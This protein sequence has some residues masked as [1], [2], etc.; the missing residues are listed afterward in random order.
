MT[1]VSELARRID[2]AI[3]AVEDKAQQQMRARLQEFQTRQGQITEYEKAQTRIVEIAK[4][5]LEALA[6]RAGERAK[7]TPAVSQTRRAATFEF[8]S[9]KA[10]MDLTFAVA[11]DQDLKRAV[12]ECDLKVVPVLWKFDSHSEF[13]TPID[14]VDA[15]GLTRWLDDR[16][17]SFVDLFIQV[18]EGEIFDKAEMVEDPV[19][20]ISFPKFAAGATLE[21]EGKMYFF[22]DE[23]T[24]AEFA[25]QK[26][27]A[28]A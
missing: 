10:K 22:I 21:H 9:S 18:H 15:D 28:K 24:K 16:I 2:A 1:D 5:R 23:R 26:G 20:K 3:S 17:L 6:K 8:K 13:G 11:P 19:E 4:P 14:K 12:V 25:R 27:I 7:I